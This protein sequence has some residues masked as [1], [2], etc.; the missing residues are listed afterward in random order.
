MPGT[1]ENK[2]P[3]GV[4]CGAGTGGGW[5]PAPPDNG[6]PGECSNPEICPEAYQKR[7]LWP[8][9]A[10]I[11]DFNVPFIISLT[12]S[13]DGDGDAEAS[14]ARITFEN[15][16][17]HDE[18]IPSLAPAEKYQVDIYIPTYCSADGSCSFD[19]MADVEEE[20]EESGEANNIKK[21]ICEQD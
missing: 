14:T 3:W 13:N 18:P 17:I 11:F 10:C 5:T 16:I 4:T 9:V 2:V 15:G 20:V 7:D 21:G 19:I 1:F 12:I 6:I 8:R